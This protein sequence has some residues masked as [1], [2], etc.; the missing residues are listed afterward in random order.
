[1]ALM[2]AHWLNRKPR[3][4]K[5]VGALFETTP[6]GEE[7]FFVRLTNG[8]VLS[9]E[10]RMVNSHPDTPIGPLLGNLDSTE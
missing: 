4:I 3:L 10:V 9:I 8:D 7:H 5:E 1:M 6:D 2:I